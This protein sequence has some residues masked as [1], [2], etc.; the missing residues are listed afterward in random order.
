MK[1]TS[2]VQTLKRA[3]VRRKELQ[4]LLGISLATIDR[5]RQTGDFPQP[6]KLG[7]QAVGFRMEDLEAWLASRELKTT[8]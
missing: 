3:I 7:A 5:M 1:A 6:I 8:H 2:V 4:E